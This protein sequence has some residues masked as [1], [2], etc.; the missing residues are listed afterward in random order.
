M[1][2]SDEPRPSLDL[3]FRD[4]A[5]GCG[6]W[7]NDGGYRCCDEPASVTAIASTP[8]GLDLWVKPL[9]DAHFQEVFDAVAKAGLSL[10][11]QRA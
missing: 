4:T 11:V 7:L 6:Y 8:A 2:P 3:A 9:C 5:P 1:Q 10:E